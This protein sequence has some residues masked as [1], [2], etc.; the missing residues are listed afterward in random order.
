MFSKEF[1]RESVYAW[2]KTMRF[3]VDFAW[4][5]SGICNG[6]SIASFFIGEEST[7]KIFCLLSYICLLIEVVLLLIV[8]HKISKGKPI[9]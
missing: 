3:V 4:W 9:A 7:V 5:L 1:E 6:L 8:V 2:R